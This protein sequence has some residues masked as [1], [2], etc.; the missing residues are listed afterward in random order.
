MTKTHEYRAEVTWT[1]ATEGPVKDYRGYDRTYTIAIAGKPVLMGSADP[2]FL[3]NPAL[4]NPEDL[5]VAAL[6]ACHMLTYLALAARAGLEVRA[7]SDSASGIMVLEG[8]GGR[9]TEVTLRPRVS[10]APGSDLE[11][12]HALHDTAHGD[13]FIANSVNFPVRNEAKVFEAADPGS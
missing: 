1:G 2:M 8:G 5:L 7:Y 4:H 10:L 3:G 6:S 12:A 13:C 9:F 11:R